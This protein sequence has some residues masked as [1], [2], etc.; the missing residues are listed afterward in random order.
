[1]DALAPQ[2]AIQR[3]E[4]D[5]EHPT[6]SQREETVC[7]ERYDIYSGRNAGELYT[8]QVVTIHVPFTGDP[9][10]FHYQATTRTICPRPIWLTAN[11]VC[12]DVIVT[13]QPSADMAGEVKRM[14]SC[15]SDN[16][17]YVNQEIVRFNQS[18]PDL[19]KGFVDRRRAELQQRLGILESLGLPLKRAEAAPATMS[20]PVVRKTLP[21][22]KP[23]PGSTPYRRAWTLDPKTYEEILQAIQDR[24]RSWERLPRAYAAKGEEALRDELIVQLASQFSWAS[25][26]G[27]TFNKT[28]KTDILMRYEQ[29]NLFVAECKFWRG[30]QQ[31][32]ATIDQ[33][34]KYLTWRDSKTAIVYFVD[35]RE[36]SAPLKAIQEYTPEHPCFV[37]ADGAHGESRFDFTFHLPEDGERTLR[38]AI[39]CF[40]LP[41]SKDDQPS[42]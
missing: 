19:A 36:V 30:R 40:H 13:T 9:T 41:K 38:V 5:V 20:V 21:P 34:L 42:K 31:H 35:T 24:G 39:V 16:V 32:L 1:M 6:M 37:A 27:E 10:V 17:R 3:L 33:L 2:F 15:L 22:P 8:R 25:T 29:E 23:L 12:F 7:A 4:V 28:G 14:L 11:E 18:L 26:T